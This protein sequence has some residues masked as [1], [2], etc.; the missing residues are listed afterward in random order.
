MR[1]LIVGGLCMM[2]ALAMTTNAWTATRLSID[3]MSTITGGLTRFCF[4]HTCGGSAD[5]CD[6][7]PNGSCA[8]GTDKACDDDERLAVGVLNCGALTNKGLGTCTPGALTHCPNNSGYY[9]C[10]CVMQRCTHTQVDWYGYTAG[11][12]QP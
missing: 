6:Q 3:E 5:G 7:E 4:N 12:P 9:N 10:A 8:P 2:F 11:C 1:T